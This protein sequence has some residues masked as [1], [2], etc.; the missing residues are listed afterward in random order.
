MRVA[1]IDIGSNTIK[2][3]IADRGDDGAFRRVF[4]TA[5]TTRLGEGIHARRLR[6]AAIRRTLDGLH[7]FVTTCRGNG[8]EQVAAVGTSA[9]RDAVNQQEFVE[10]ARAIG[11]E[12]QP[13]SGEEEARLSFLAV[14]RDP[15][16]ATEAGILVID[17]GGGSTEVIWGGSAREPVRLLSLPLGGVRLTEDALRSDPPSIMQMDEANG[18]AREVLQVFRPDVPNLTAVGVGGTLTN[19][20]AVRHGVVGHDPD[21]LHGLRLTT[22]DIEEQVAL[23]GGM[24]VA[25]RREVPGLDPARADIIL[26][27][28]IILSH[29]LNAAGLD[30]VSVSCRGLRWGVLYDRFGATR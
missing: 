19:V 12:V 27:G 8:V 21:A 4:E 1:A 5:S 24:T 22:D 9:L 13:I 6:E 23:Y 28:A 30:S 10:R 17:I 14:R 29:V 11:V 16:W 7:A 26:G 3:V 18:I 15:R 25:Q 2:L 20:A